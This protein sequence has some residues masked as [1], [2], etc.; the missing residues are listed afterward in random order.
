MS[1]RLPLWLFALATLLPPCALAVSVFMPG[2]TALALGLTALVPVFLDLLLPRV[3]GNEEGAFP[4]GEFPKGEFPQSGLLLVLIGVL[5]LASLP[6]GVMAVLRLASAADGAEALAFGL[7]LSLWLGQVG[8][9]AA[10]EMIHKPG[11]LL[12]TLGRALYGVFLFGHHP[13]AHRFVHHLHVGTD[14]D[15]NS[16]P[17]GMG[18]YRF[19][20]T[21]WPKSLRAGLKAD[22][23]PHPGL[24]LAVYAGVGAA[25]AFGAGGI[26]GL[27]IW[28]GLSFQFGA[29]VLLADY[30]QHYGLRRSPGAPITA[31]L[32][33]NAPHWASSALMLNAT[34][35][36]D[37]HLH[38]ARSYPDLR[39]APA[40]PILPWPLPL[41]CVVALYPPLWRRRMAQALSR[42]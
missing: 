12:P 16:A 37:H 32:S 9:P 30:V 26:P 2:V 13:A 6:L 19:L 40:I 1:R 20:V 14:K 3:L 17:R 25:L 41:A 15:P 21:A 29:Q 5:A 22:R 28:L 39:L 24:R 33:W 8:H 36:S 23:T 18:F 31:A 35:H 34:R 11:R 7:G 38:P 10:H 27:G 42:L 4:T